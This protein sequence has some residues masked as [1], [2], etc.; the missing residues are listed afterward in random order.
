MVEAALNTR[1]DVVPVERVILVASE[2][3]RGSRFVAERLEPETALA[4]LMTMIFLGANSP[5]AIA[6]FLQVCGELASS[7]PIFLART[8]D[9]VHHLREALRDYISKIASKD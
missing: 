5:P 7:V 6:H 9:G 1:G 2:R 4:E 3:R 8:P